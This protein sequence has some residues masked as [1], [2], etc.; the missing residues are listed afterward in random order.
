MEPS[1]R[2]EEKASIKSHRRAGRLPEEMTP[3]S[4]H[5]C[6]GR[7]GG[8]GALHGPNGV[9]AGCC[10]E[11]ATDKLPPASRPEAARS[12]RLSRPHRLQAICGAKRAIS[13]DKGP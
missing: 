4:T 3:L 1:A 11:E 10:E 6:A 5:G 7:L 12:R 9:Q 2:A 8:E 13:K